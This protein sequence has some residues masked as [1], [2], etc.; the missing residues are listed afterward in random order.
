MIF[1]QGLGD[2]FVIRVAGNVAAPTQVGSIE[3]AASKFGVPLCVVLGHTHC[4]AIAATIDAI[5]SP[6]DSNGED[7]IHSIVECIGPAISDLVD[8]T[9]ESGTTDL[10]AAATRRNVEACVTHLQQQ[11]PLLKQLIA[12]DQFHVIG[13]Q[14]DIET[15]VVEFYDGN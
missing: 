13:A 10:M 12:N 2:L 11:S 3:F 14:Y 6:S 8:G 5:Q 1:D 4:G 7:S 15:G 9:A